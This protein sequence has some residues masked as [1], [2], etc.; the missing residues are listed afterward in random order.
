[1]KVTCFDAGVKLR[2]RARASVL[3]SLK[4]PAELAEQRMYDCRRSLTAK[5]I[6]PELTR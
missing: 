5:R 3:P 2:R 1:M 6:L 4:G